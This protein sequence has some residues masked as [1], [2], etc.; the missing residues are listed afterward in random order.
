MKIAIMTRLLT[1]W[2]VNVDAAHFSIQ[3]SIAVGSRSLLISQVSSTLRINHTKY[4]FLN[5]NTVS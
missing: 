2:N 4:L 3:F 5:H 1:E